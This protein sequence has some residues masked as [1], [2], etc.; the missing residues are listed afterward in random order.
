MDI[1]TY[2]YHEGCVKRDLASNYGG[3]KDIDPVVLF[4]TLGIG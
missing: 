4:S 1:I 3:P 2:M